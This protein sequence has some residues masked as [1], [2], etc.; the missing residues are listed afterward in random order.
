ML[1][2]RRFRALII[3]FVVSIVFSLGGT[4]PRVGAVEMSQSASSNSIEQKAPERGAT[5]VAS[6]AQAVHEAPAAAQPDSSD[7]P[8]TT[9]TLPKV[10][11]ILLIMLTLAKVGGDLFERV[12]QPAVLGEL[13]FGIVLGN[14]SLFKLHALEDFVQNVVRDRQVDTFITLLSE[15]GVALLLFEVGLEATVGEMV[16]VGA[17]SFVVAVL[18]VIT[19]MA[20]GFATGMAFM[21]TAPWTVH[22]FLGSVLA[23][24]SVG[25]T[26]RV[27]R[28]LNKMHLRESKIILGAAVIDDIL[29]LVVLAVVQGLVVAANTGQTL[30]ITAIVWVVVKAMLFFVAAIVIGMLVSKRLYRLATYLHVQGVLLTLTLGWCFLIAYLGTLFGLAPIVGAFAAGLVLEEATF[31]DWQGR[32]S[33]LEDL[34]RPITTFLVPVF[35]VHMGMR[36]QLATFGNPAILGF[37]AVLTLAAIFGKQVC[38]LGALEKGL[39]RVAIGVGMI[40]R[41][42]VGLIVASIGAT[43]KTSNGQPVISTE[44]FSATVIM[45]TVTTMVTPPILKW[46]FE[47]KVN[48]NSAGQVAQDT[49]SE[50]GKV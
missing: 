22:L 11:L 38:S 17:S 4:V 37:A 8:H 1:N 13:I 10:L 47:R 43:M 32:E 39:N 29:G 36:V 45:V 20:L 41:G 15:I 31:R 27:L 14:L 49:A 48:G 34:L 28:D 18:G 46:A 30:E 12:G 33:Q 2:T 24:T 42:E 5:E 7:G 6:A 3:A 9:E 44:A 26:A 50:T 25:I 19:P 21:P 23:A 35:F 40:P 16:S